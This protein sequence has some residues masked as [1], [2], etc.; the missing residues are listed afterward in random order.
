MTNLTGMFEQLNN[1]IKETPLAA[2]GPGTPPG[3]PYNPMDNVNPMMQQFAQ[4]VGNM[5]GFDPAANRT[6]AQ[7]MT[8]SNTEASSAMESED[9]QML[10][11]AA[12]LMMK[13]GRT[14]E[15]QQ[16]TQR[17]DEIKALAKTEATEAIEAAEEAATKAKE[18]KTLENTILT[19]RARKQYKWAE[20]LANGTATV[21]DYMK[22]VIEERTAVG[23][24]RRKAS[25][26]AL[27]PSVRFDFEFKDGVWYKIDKTGVL[28]PEATSKVPAEALDWQELTDA[29]DN[30]IGTYAIDGNG[31]VTKRDLEGNP[32][33]PSDPGGP[34]NEAEQLSFASAADY[35]T[36]MLQKIDE[37]LTLWDSGWSFGFGEGGLAASQWATGGLWGDA[38][39]INS[40]LGFIKANLTFDK[41]VEI[42]AQ[43]STLGQITEK[44]FE[45]LG[46]SLQNLNPESQEF[47]RAL[48]E[49]GDLVKR[50]QKATTT[51][52]PEEMVDWSNPYSASAVGGNVRIDPATLRIE[53]KLDDDS[54]W[55]VTTQH[56]APGS[57]LAMEA[58]QIAAGRVETVTPEV[59][60]RSMGY[61]NKTGPGR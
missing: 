44:E 11:Q 45:A 52:H 31:K 19:A 60:N 3:M 55:Y 47:G 14:A 36:R 2:K 46:A 32:I 26:D 56:P 25:A 33:K 49:Y 40:I 7:N 27:K 22:F 37:A 57:Q 51:G 4:G 15:A 53:V 42:K 58:E 17:A 39:E 16:L 18:M 50:Q 6:S 5:A 35:Q 28:S 10:I 54:D 29:D 9:P 59:A 48:K 1:T 34:R 30:L 61:F 41:L 8:I 38:K 20:D 12:S 13:Q 43:G 21:A 24:E 23:T